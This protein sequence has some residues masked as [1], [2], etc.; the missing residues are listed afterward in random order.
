[1][2]ALVAQ[3]N[4]MDKLSNG[5]ENEITILVENIYPF[6]VHLE[7]IDELPYQFQ[8]RNTSF[9]LTLKSGAKKM[10]TYPLRPTARG[11]YEF[12]AINCFASSKIGLISRKMQFSEHAKVPV[13]PSFIQMRHFELLAFSNR[14]TQ[15]GIKKIRKIGRNTEFE[16]I[17]EYVAGDDFKTINWKATARKDKLMVNQ[18]QEEKSQNVYSIIDMGRAMKMPFKGLTLMDYAINASLVISNIIIKKYD[19]A[20]LIT[21]NNKLKSVLKAEHKS[22]HIQKIM[23]L[24]YSQKTGY[25]ES[26]F[27]ELYTTIKYKLNQ[28]S[29]LL[30]YT[31][32]ETI[33]SLQRQMKYLRGIAKNHL[34]VVIFFENTELT[35][36]AT[37]IANT[38]EEIYFQTIAEK[39]AY[40]KK[41]ILKQLQNNG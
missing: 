11:E 8:V 12:G 27:E 28:R 4:T 33:D 36:L 10:I 20:G 31:N 32:F 38:T 18:Y 13:Y 9:E 35:T 24:L 5:D 16:K 21:F 25:A 34:L 29:L 30:L 22:S 6:P 15:A 26:N 7:I 37:K 19:K 23:D 14:L 3:R 1:K 40:E 39:F 41:I 2:N 17:N